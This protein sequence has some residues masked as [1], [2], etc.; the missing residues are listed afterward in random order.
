M[1]FGLEARADWSNSAGKVTLILAFDVISSYVINENKYLVTLP[2]FSWY[3]LMGL[4]P[5][6]LMHSPVIASKETKRTSFILF[7]LLYLIIIIM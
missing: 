3:G 7:I 4:R 2:L 6:P 5:I 1:H